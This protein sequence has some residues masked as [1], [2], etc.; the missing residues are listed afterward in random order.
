MASNE[1][2]PMDCD[3]QD[4]GPLAKQSDFSAKKD[5]AELKVSLSTA[6]EFEPKK[7]KSI[8]TKTLQSWAA[9]NS[10]RGEFTATEISEDGK[11]AVIK[12]VPAEALQELLNISG[13]EL[14]TKEKKTFSITP[15][16]AEEQSQEDKKSSGEYSSLKLQKAHNGSVDLGN[17]DSPANDDSEK[18]LVALGPYWYMK[19]I[20]RDDIERIEKQNGVRITENVAVSINAEKHGA[21]PKKA[22][23]EF[24]E[25]VQSCLNISNGLSIP[26]KD[27]GPQEWRDTLKFL[28]A[29]EHKCQITISADQITIFGPQQYQTAILKSL[30]RT[31]ISTNLTDE[32]RKDDYSITQGATSSSRYNEDHRNANRNRIKI[33]SSIK[34]SFVTD[35]LQVEEYYWKLLQD[36]YRKEL[37]RIKDKF[38]VCVKDADTTPGQKVIKVF[39]NTMEGNMQMESHAIRALLRLYQKVATSQFLKNNGT[40][41]DDQSDDEKDLYSS[42]DEPKGAAGKT[43]VPKEKSNTNGW[44]EGGAAKNQ[45]AAEAKKDEKDDIC[46]VC[47]DNFTKKTQLRC[48]HEFCEECLEQS[49]KTQGSICP[50]CKDVFGLVEGDQPPGKMTSRKR[51]TPLPGYEGWDSIEIIYDIPDGIQTDKHPSPGQTYTGLCRSAY[52]PDNREGNEVLHLLKRAFDQKLIFTVGTS[53]TTG[54]NNM[55]TWNDIHHKTSTHGGPER[56]GYPDPNYLS[57]VKEELKAKGIK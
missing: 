15:I 53:R 42:P 50:V 52:L 55:V 20:H 17:K 31:K 8:I 41:H 13:K 12:I 23:D 54:A 37:D 16:K 33:T 27:I 46:P 56:F 22:S 1:E 38:N 44:T 30:K 11:T 2:E 32:E 39:Y 36:Q 34:D 4:K 28:Q 10:I 21:D 51:Y 9:K 7:F 5:V 35:G 24:T 26:L 25:L 6:E 29:T 14:N 19:N 43:Y 45:S 48:K 3:T 57:R 40:F 47:L 18:T 49:V